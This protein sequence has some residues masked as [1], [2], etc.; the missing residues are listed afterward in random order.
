MQASS[1]CIPAPAL[2]TQRPYGYVVKAAPFRS[3]MA[4]A[5]VALSETHLA[6]NPSRRTRADR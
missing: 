6:G 5:R 1:T 2:P 3:D 4:S